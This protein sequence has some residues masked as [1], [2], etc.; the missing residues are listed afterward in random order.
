MQ[1][2]FNLCNGV[3]TF[4]H[5]LYYFL[6]M[7]RPIVLATYSNSDAQYLKYLNQEMKD[8]WSCFLR[9]QLDGELEYS[10]PPFDVATDDFEVVIEHVSHLAIFHY[11]GHANPDSL[12]IEEKEFA[13][14]QLLKLLKGITVD[15]VILNGC[16]TEGF[17]D[18]MLRKGVKAVIATE[19]RIGDL[20][21]SRF[22]T[23]FYKSLLKGNT[24]LDAFDNALYELNEAQLPVKRGM[25][26]SNDPKKRC[27]WGIYYDK[28][29]P[30][31]A[32]L[33]RQF[34]LIDPAERQISPPPNVEIEGK[35]KQ[36][37]RSIERLEKA[38][39][40]FEKL[41]ESQSLDYLLEDLKL[42]FDPADPAAT[43]LA[44]YRQI[45]NL[46]TEQ[47]KPLSTTALLT[48]FSAFD[49]QEQRAI[50][51]A[52]VDKQFVD[53][54]LSI[55]KPIMGAFLLQGSPRCGLGL[56]QR[57]IQ[58][59]YE[60]PLGNESIELI[61]ILLNTRT[62][63]PL[64]TDLLAIWQAV[65]GKI[66]KGEASSDEITVEIIRRHRLK[67]VVIAFVGG[68]LPE[69]NLAILNDFWTDFK[70]KFSRNQP[71]PV[72]KVLLF[73]QAIF[74]GAIPYPYDQ[75]A[76]TDNDAYVIPMVKRVNPGVVDLWKTTVSISYPYDMTYFQ[77]EPPV[78]DALKEI[79]DKLNK[80][81]Q[82]YG[83]IYNDYLVNYTTILKREPL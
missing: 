32:A 27:P 26:R 12:L 16:S 4:L 35:I 17:V 71:T 48:K 53:A 42:F 49:Y 73:V 79:C 76:T 29:N 83:D 65:G 13:A 43:V 62:T 46:L 18:E 25:L 34:R 19:R 33:A 11:S 59:S 64:G 68:E 52:I 69:T 28:D 44:L 70:E 37:Q 31:K 80:R 39:I 75:W 30:V 77:N 41:G 61:K 40:E 5:F 57:N 78:M 47:Y 20:T 23:L 22:A 21:A 36:L 8:I 2:G 55:P 72:H 51:L 58:D 15:V 63:T 54:E 10:A 74:G 45:S 9:T 67:P 56:L 14:S 81:D 50:Y 1:E 82:K 24:L 3:E 38:I 7:S 60:L 6:L 66:G